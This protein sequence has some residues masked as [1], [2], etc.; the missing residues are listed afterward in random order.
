MEINEILKENDRRRELLF[1]GVDQI[2]G[3]GVG[4]GRKLVVIPDHDIPEQWLTDEVIR[5]PDYQAVMEAGS[6]AALLGKRGKD[7]SFERLC[8]S[9]ELNRQRM[10]HDPYFAFAKAFHIKNKITGKLVPFKLNYAQRLLLDEFEAMRT[11][12]KPIRLILLKARQWGG[13]TLIQLYM[14]WIQLF[15]KDGWNSLIVAQTKDTARRIK[16]MYTKVLM[17][18]PKDVF[19]KG[20]LK[21]SPYE[22]SAADSVITDSHGKPVRSNVITVSSYEN[23][24]STRGCDVAMAHFSEVAYWRLT[25]QKSASA[26]IRAVTSGIAEG[27]ACTMEVMESTAN[28]K[29]GYFYD[30]YQEAKEGHSARKAL[31]IPF[32]YIEHDTLPFQDDAEREAFAEQLLQHSRDS[33]TTEKTAEPG[34]YLWKLWVKGATLEHIKWYVER[35]KS[36]HSHAQIASEAPSDDI[37]CFTFSG[38]LIINPEKVDAAEKKEKRQPV[39]RGEVTI[40]DGELTHKVADENGPLKIWEYPQTGDYDNRYL[41]TVDVGGRME[42]SDYSVITVIDRSHANVPVEPLYDRDEGEKAGLWVVARWRGHCRFD[43]LAYKAVDIGWWYDEALVVFESNTFDQ[44]K[45]LAEEFSEHADHAVSVLEEVKRNYQNVYTRSAKNPD[46]IREGIIRKIGFQTNRRTKQQMVDQ[47]TKWFEDGLFHDPD[48][49]FYKELSIYEERTDGSY[50]NIP[51]NGNHDDIVMTDMIANL[52][53][54]QQPRSLPPDRHHIR[55]PAA[56]RTV[57]ESSF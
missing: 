28:G 55:K 31:F 18:F 12:G 22:R 39:F 3:K 19:K 40:V 53:H 17:N 36:F 49:A 46:D 27:V 8:F 56:N 33:V 14:A 13:S 38:H 16:A 26:L 48:E 11:A 30:E 44:K 29:S 9:Q 24:E 41:I 25:P 2:T 42:Q 20:E 21:F 52:V 50:G 4:G 57:N 35:R 51:G 34:D 32:F 15:V 7:T 1:A 37:E 43:T 23:Y 10:A 5:L 45:G 54:Q 6:I 47:F